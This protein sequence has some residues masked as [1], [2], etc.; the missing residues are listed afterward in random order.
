M[1]ITKVEWGGKNFRA[2]AHGHT[3]VGELCNE[4]NRKQQQTC[5]QKLISKVRILT[6]NSRTLTGLQH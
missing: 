3:N 5:I 4:R 1:T 2:S 6:T